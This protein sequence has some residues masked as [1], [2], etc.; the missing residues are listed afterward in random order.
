LAAVVVFVGVPPVLLLLLL[1]LLLWFRNRA[2]AEVGDRPCSD[3][4][5][6]T[7]RDGMTSPIRR[8]DDI[9]LL[10]PLLLLLLLLLRLRRTSC[11]CC[12]CSSIILA[13][14]DRRWRMSN[15]G[16]G[17]GNYADSGNSKKIP[18]EWGIRVHVR[19]DTAVWRR[20]QD[21]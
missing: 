7:E 13:P 6:D 4:V 5:D 18:R 11:C 1:L 2:D 9:M 20:S 19:S 3:C 10:L 15:Q 17:H 14:C 21:T 16:I 8:C 12:C